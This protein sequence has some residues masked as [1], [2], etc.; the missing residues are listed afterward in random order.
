[1]SSDTKKSK[2]KNLF[3]AISGIGSHVGDMLKNKEPYYKVRPFGGS[4]WCVMTFAEMTEELKTAETGDV[5]E[6]EKVSMTDEQLN[7]LPEFQGW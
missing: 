2:P 7:A 4:C 3:D 5:W 6:I 1:M